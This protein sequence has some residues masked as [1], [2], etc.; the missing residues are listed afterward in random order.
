MSMVKLSSSTSNFPCPVVCEDVSFTR[1]LL[2]LAHATA[3]SPGS[4]YRPGSR[5]ALA[6]YSTVEDPRTVASGSLDFVVNPGIKDLDPH[7]KT[8]LSD[9]MGV[10]ISLALID[11]R[12]GIR[13][14]YDTYQLVSTRRASLKTKGRH[15]KMPDFVLLLDRP[16]G[17]EDIILLECKGSTVPGA[18]KKQLASACASQ[19]KN[20]KSVFGTNA[21][22]IPKLAFASQ[23]LLGNQLAVHVA[24]PPMILDGADDLRAILMANYLALEFSMFGDFLSAQKV[25]EA[26][27]LPSWRAEEM[28]GM[29]LQNDMLQMVDES[30]SN[31]GEKPRYS[32]RERQRAVDL[33]QAQFS[34]STIKISASDSAR[35]IRAANRWDDL[36]E[37]IVTEPRQVSRLQDRAGTRRFFVEDSVSAAGVRATRQITLW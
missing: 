31:L 16:V 22:F 20:V 29:S 36:A 10:A 7:Q 11:Q 35:N 19:L 13:G 1:A 3:P 26:F 17:D 2:L 14:I 8:V 5:W 33:V 12:Y 18:H 37:R 4:R 34:M 30:L 23:L 21:K 25:W 6:R 32:S 24:D 9:D 15:R 28:P 27:E